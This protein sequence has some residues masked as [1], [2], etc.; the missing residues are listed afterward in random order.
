MWG[1]DDQRVEIRSKI[2]NKHTERYQQK[3]QQLL[4]VHKND[5]KE[6]FSIKAYSHAYVHYFD[7]APLCEI[8]DLLDSEQIGMKKIYHDFLNAVFDG[9]LSVLQTWHADYNAGVVKICEEN[10]DLSS[11]EKVKS[12]HKNL[13]SIIDAFLTLSLKDADSVRWHVISIA[14]NHKDSLN[15]PNFD[16]LISLVVEI[17]TEHHAMI[18]NK[19]CFSS[20]NR[21]ET[22]L[23]VIRRANVSEY[24]M[25]CMY[26][27]IP[28]LNDK[29]FWLIFEDYS[30]A[31][32]TEEHL[33]NAYKLLHE[34]I[35]GAY[36][37][38]RSQEATEALRLYLCSWFP[39]ALL[40]KIRS[41]KILES[42]W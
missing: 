7:Y 11:S 8:D 1:A 4:G 23:R 20:Y 18:L 30:D 24:Y 13:V 2:E 41:C 5:E 9:F 33:D 35:K 17:P 15:L 27:F 42:C 10:I 32:P 29:S 38:P 25:K 19:S 31:I 28:F 3:N 21:V 40:Y 26:Q 37:L 12:W 36:F 39:A 22:W 14:I 6:L 16:H 34:R